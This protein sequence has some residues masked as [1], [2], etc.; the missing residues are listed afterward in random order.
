MVDLH[1]DKFTK[2][3]RPLFENYRVS[4]GVIVQSYKTQVVLF[5]I[6]RNRKITVK[7]KK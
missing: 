6:F 4:A 3:N 5:W 2:T 1:G 7:E